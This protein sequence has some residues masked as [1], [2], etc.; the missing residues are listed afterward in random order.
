LAG[1]CAKV[2]SSRRRRR[3]LPRATSLSRSSCLCL[4]Q[5]LDI[6]GCKARSSQERTRCRTSKNRGR[7]CVVAAWNVVRRCFCAERFTDIDSCP[8]RSHSGSTARSWSGGRIDRTRRAA[9]VVTAG[10]R[11]RPDFCPPNLSENNRSKSC[12]RNPAGLLER[13][14]HGWGRR[15]DPQLIRRSSTEPSGMPPSIARP[16]PEVATTSAPALDP[17]VTR[18]GAWPGTRS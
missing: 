10:L 2:R 11:C 8:A 5:G 6:A 17:P 13:S 7:Y 1:Q 9:L 14:P 4:A 12:A 15:P 16:G 18:I 3:R